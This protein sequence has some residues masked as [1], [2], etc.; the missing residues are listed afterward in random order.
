MVVL[1]MDNLVL[2]K[3]LSKIQIWCFF[4]RI[5]SSTFWP[6]NT[7]F[8]FPFIIPWQQHLLPRD[9]MGLK[10]KKRV[11]HSSGLAW[12]TWG[13]YCPL[14]Q[15]TCVQPFM[16]HHG[17]LLN[18]RSFAGCMHPARIPLKKWNPVRLCCMLQSIRALLLRAF[19]AAGWRLLLLVK[20]LVTSR[21]SQS[22]HL[23]ALLTLLL[24]SPHFSL[25]V[26]T[27]FH[28]LGQKLQNTKG[29]LKS[30]TAGRWQCTSHGQHEN[31]K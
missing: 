31:S 21:S 3:C 16:P 5:L 6:G 25:F 14:Q 20:L 10:Q 9:D 29:I 7:T 27:T 22:F 8:P 28:A 11:L 2:P 18:L 26:S 1:V 24:F 19:W 12:S 15:M 17:M 4:H 13:F 23:G 30:F